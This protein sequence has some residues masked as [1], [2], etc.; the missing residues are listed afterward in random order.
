MFATAK[1]AISAY[2]S[3]KIESGV[4]AASPHKLVLMLYEGAL[5]ALAD[6]KL[7]MARRETAAKGQALSKA[8]MI[9]EGLKTSLD[10]KAGGELGER[11][12]A[13]YEYMCDRLLHA[14][15]HNRPE[16]IEEV[17]QLLITLRGAWEQINPA[18]APASTSASEMPPPASAKAAS[19]MTHHRA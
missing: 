4:E 10:I 7:H 3:V 2:T 5:L 17:S 1:H 15:L 6:A 19:T 16:I 12:A 14:N 13:L 8:I 11:L 9:I 18:T